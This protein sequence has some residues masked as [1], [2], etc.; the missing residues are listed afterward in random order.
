M[1]STASTAASSTTASDGIDGS[2][3]RTDHFIAPSLNERQR[4]SPVVLLHL[5]PL[6]RGHPDG[7]RATLAERRLFAKDV[8]ST[9]E[10]EQPPPSGFAFELRAARV[11]DPAW[12][13]RGQ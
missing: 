11:A 8:I 13:V 9:N 10:Q 6:K 5:P 1:C 4:C 12:L 2:A 3:E 7:V